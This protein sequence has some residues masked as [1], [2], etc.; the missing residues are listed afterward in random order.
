MLNRLTRLFARPGIATPPTVV[1]ST[2]NAAAEGC[3]DRGN[4]HV[5][6][7]ALDAAAACY[8]DAIAIDPSYA[9][10]HNNLGVVLMKQGRLDDAAGSFR[11]ALNIK[12]GLARAH[13][14]CGVIEMAQGRLDEARGYFHAALQFDPCL[15][16]AHNNLGSLFEAER[17]TEKALAHFREA[18]RLDPG[19][20]DAHFNL[21]ELQRRQGNAEDA[22]ASL[23]MAV[24]LKPDFAEANNSVG[25][26]AAGRADWKQ[27]KV[28]FDAA[29]SLKP[30]Y[31]AAAHNLG[32]AH[33]ESGELDEAAVRFRKVIDLQPSFSGGYAGLGL[34]MRQQGDMDGAVANFRKAVLLDPLDPNVLS[35]LALVLQDRDEFDEAIA[36][37]EKA[38]S[39][40]PLEN[41]R[42]FNLALPLLAT[43]RLA[44]GWEGYGHRFSADVARRTFE[45]TEWTGQD[46]E[47]KALLLWSEQGIGDQIFWAN[48]FPDIIAR[49][50]RCVIECAPKLVPLF[51]NS[52]PDAQIVPA[53]SRPHPA[54][55]EGIDFQC[56]M[57]S[58]PKWL[59]PTPGSFPRHDGYLVPPPLRVAYWRERLSA[60]GPEPKVGFSWC[61]HVVSDVRWLHYTRLT[62]WSPIFRRHGF[63]FVSLQYDRR[64]GEIAEVE[65]LCDVPLHVFPEVD[66]FDDL[67]EAAAL[68]KAL[69]LVLSAPTSTSFLAAA[70]GVPTWMMSYGRPWQMMGTD[71]IPGFPAMRC[72]PR[73]WDQPWES[74]I[75]AVAEALD[76]RLP[77]GA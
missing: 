72:F 69:D 8:R 42:R 31:W 16:E 51:A 65:R 22:L 21:G 36:C 63:H 10:A 45:A 37:Y 18:A 17:D 74:V 24:Q 77:R 12:P 61:G 14:N 23:R 48:L 9:E 67:V 55:Q 50:D 68:T 44:A 46:L 43:G 53:T 59:R 70:L 54:T 28:S 30:D 26:I 27:A 40:R 76:S 33:Y 3:K 2:P 13:L 56:G 58:P 20:P 71:G 15:A 1:A 38:L 75:E 64:S 57:A 5:A 62:Q 7:G 6:E 52:F 32:L 47:G 49:A 66:L 41:W 39:L 4:A 11:Q 29:V 19:L 35:N 34:V 60:L 25:M 73:R